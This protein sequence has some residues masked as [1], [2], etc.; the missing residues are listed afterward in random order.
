MFAQA[1]GQLHVQRHDHVA[2]HALLLVDRKALAFQSHLRPVLRL[3]FHRELDIPF[4]RSKR[5]LATQK[6]SEQVHVQSGVQVVPDTFEPGV[7]P[8]TEGDVE[9]AVGATVHTRTA[10]SRDPD[11]LSVLHA[12]GYRDADLLPVH[13]EHLLVRV[14]G[15]LQVQV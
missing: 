8:D 15:L 6:G 3:W 9:I 11:G 2:I 1:G 12:C 10:M 14:H 5:A 4:Q 13:R 7:V